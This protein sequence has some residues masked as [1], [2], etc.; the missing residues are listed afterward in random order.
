MWLKSRLAGL[1]EVSSKLEV[2]RQR[3]ALAKLSTDLRALFSSLCQVIQD[4]PNA[5]N[6]PISYIFSTKLFCLI[7]FFPYSQWG[8]EGSAMFQYEELGEEVRG[9][10]EEVLRTQ[11][12]A[13][14][15]TS[16]ILDAEGLEEAKQLYLIHQVCIV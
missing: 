14:E 8:E 16:R 12:E 11:G 4:I 15:Q 1:S 7:L 3:T 6:V 9:A 13:E 5:K 2:Q 10:L